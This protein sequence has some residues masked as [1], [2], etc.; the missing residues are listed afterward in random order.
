MPPSAPASLSQV[1]NEK[2]HARARALSIG[3]RTVVDGVWIRR[4][5]LLTYDVS[6]MRLDL[7]EVAAEVAYLAAERDAIR[8]EPSL[9]RAAEVVG[10]QR[11]TGRFRVGIERYVG[12]IPIWEATW[13]PG[14]VACCARE[15]SFALDAL[16][17][18]AREMG[19]TAERIGYHVV[20]PMPLADRPPLARATHRQSRPSLR[21]PRGASA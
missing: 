7:D 13:T 4:S 11:H 19:L 10:R 8:E 6:G 15:P 3:E 5:S 17:A 18:Y 14:D 12:R 16:A 1:T 20:S 21:Q 2:I 9:G